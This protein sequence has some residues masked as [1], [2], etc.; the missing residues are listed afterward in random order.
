MENSCAPTDSFTLSMAPPSSLQHNLVHCDP[1]DHARLRRLVNKTF[2][3]AATA[4]AATPT[5]TAFS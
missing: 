4:A 5:V 1:L 2:T 3:R